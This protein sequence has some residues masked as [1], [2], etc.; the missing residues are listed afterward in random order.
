MNWLLGD[1]SYGATAWDAYPPVFIES[2]TGMNIASLTW[3]SAN[4]G[5][6]AV[7]V[8][9]NFPGSPAIGTKFTAQVGNNP[10]IPLSPCV[11]SG[12]NGSFPGAII[13]GANSFTYPLATNPGAATKLGQTNAPGGYGTGVPC[14]DIN[15]VFAGNSWANNNGNGVG[16]YWY[17]AVDSNGISKW[18]QSGWNSF[19]VAVFANVADPNTKPGLLACSLWNAPHKRAIS[20]NKAQTIFSKNAS[21][22]QFNTFQ[23]MGLMQCIGT[24]TVD[25]ANVYIAIGPNC[26]N[27]FFL[28]DASTLANCTK[29]MPCTID[30]WSAG[31]VTI[32]PRQGAFTTISG[33]Y[34]Y[35]SDANNNIS[36]AGQFHS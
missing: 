31:A 4:G 1:G 17:F 32:R 35:W 11:P 3:S 26:L 7:R 5:T 22:Q 13:T 20:V 10:G 21:V 33:T 2:S 24:H 16:P 19:E 29:I 34:L 30:S 18:D 27:R 9:G 23:F 12:Y 15:M 8:S 14:S 6:V 25:R 28:G 36:L